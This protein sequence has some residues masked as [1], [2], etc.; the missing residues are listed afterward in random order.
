MLADRLTLGERRRFAPPV[1]RPIDILRRPGFAGLIRAARRGETRGREPTRRQ[2]L[3]PSFTAKSQLSFTAN[4]TI[5]PP[6]RLPAD[7]LGLDQV[8]LDEVAKM[9]QRRS[10]ARVIGVRVCA[11]VGHGLL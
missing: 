8:E 10:G 11:P 4:E 6:A 5:R 1:R 2:R 7:W 3:H 9:V